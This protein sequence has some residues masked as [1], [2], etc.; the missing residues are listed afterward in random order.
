MKV[1]WARFGVAGIILLCF[2]GRACVDVAI[3][4]L[5]VAPVFNE[6]STFQMWRL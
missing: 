3:C 1:R 5:F 4:D 6:T 2:V